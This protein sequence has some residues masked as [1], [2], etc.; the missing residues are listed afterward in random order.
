MELG[1]PRIEKRDRC[2]TC[3]IWEAMR[4]EWIQ[5][6]RAVAV[7]LQWTFRTLVAASTYLVPTLFPEMFHAH[8]L[9]HQFQYLQKKTNSNKTK[10]KNNQ[11]KPQEYRLILTK[12]L[13][14]HARGCLGEQEHCL[15]L[16]NQQELQ[17]ALQKWQTSQTTPKVSF[18]LGILEFGQ[19]KLR[20]LPRVKKE[21]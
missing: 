9:S 19:F 20:G 17:N 6:N 21:N 15:W 16:E 11:Q 14:K 2:H 5:S 10:L 7:S 8:T 1:L 13:S 3:F 18:S 4:K 12:L